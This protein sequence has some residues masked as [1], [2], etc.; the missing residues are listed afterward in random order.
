MNQ[1]LF[2]GTS[3]YSYPGKPPKGWFGAFYPEVK[4]KGFDELQYYSQI[5]N[6]V[7]INFTFYRPPSPAVTK[8]W[9]N[10]TPS[11]F[12]FAIKLWQKFTHPMKIGRKS[13]EDQW[14]PVTQ[15]DIEEFRSGIQPLAETGKLG[16]LLLQYPT[17]FHFTP[18]NQEKVE[19][20]L[21]AFYDYPKVVELRHNSWNESPEIRALLEENRAGE[22]LIDEPK[23]AS[24][25][26]QDL[27]PIG[28]I[29]YF[30]AHGRNAKAWWRPKE[31]WE[32]YDYCYSRDE[33]K[34]MAE[35]IK[36]ATSTPGIKK[37]FAFFNNH[38]RANA[39][40]NAIMLSQELGLR[41]KAMPT[42]AML[43]KFPQ[44]ANV[45]SSSTRQA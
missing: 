12:S 6:T 15:E 43:E 16:A 36:V 33:I 25:I 41:L 9:A 38:A 19:R 10:K 2:I 26:R 27:A 18:E 5:F 21:Q 8:S 40:A 3:G 29:F 28:E 42:E 4:G 20:T 23:F 14:Q 37:G 39:P 22:V 1:P 13:S 7:E 44:L 11:D 30:R 45:E 35:R 24:S 31:S 32:R 34:K 17:G